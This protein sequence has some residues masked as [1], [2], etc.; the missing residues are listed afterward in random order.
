ML[1]LKTPQYSTDR[2]Q[3]IMIIRMEHHGSIIITLEILLTQTSTFFFS[4]NS[5]WT[6]ISMT[7]YTLSM[8]SSFNLENMYV[9]VQK[10]ME[11]NRT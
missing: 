8:L 11:K 4:Y 9:G 7:M 10:S 1:P 5:V 3:Y 2:W 6:Q